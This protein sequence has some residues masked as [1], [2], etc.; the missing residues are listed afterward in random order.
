[1]HLIVLPFYLT[2]LQL[3]QSN[4]FRTELEALFILHANEMM[5]LHTKKKIEM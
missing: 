1:M 2:P 4:V 5:T 3:N